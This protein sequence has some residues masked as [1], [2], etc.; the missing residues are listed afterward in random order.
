MTKDPIGERGGLNLYVFVTNNSLSFIDP[1]GNEANAFGSSLFSFA[2]KAGTHAY[3]AT[4]KSADVFNRAVFF[5]LVD[6]LALPDETIKCL[7]GVTDE[8]LMAFAVQFPGGYDDLLFGVVI[9]AGKTPRVARK[10]LGY[11]PNKLSNALPDDGVFSR[12]MPRK[13]A[14]AFARGDG[15][16]GVGGKYDEVFIGAADDLTE[17]ATIEGAQ[18]RLS[19]FSDRAG[20]SPNL[21][22]DAVVEFKLKST[23][24]IGLRS[25]IETDPPRGYGYTPGGETAGDAREWLINSGTASEIGAYDIVVRPLK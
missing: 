22:G 20:K 10:L 1:I 4:L 25:P 14:D 11:V 8:D 19:L 9:G 16:I 6:I 12:V 2:R 13:Y 23:E 5:P 15:A 18:N 21:S 7:F 24:N 3:S 17:V